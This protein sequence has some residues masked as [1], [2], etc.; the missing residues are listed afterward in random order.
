MVIT[1]DLKNYLTE[2]IE[3]TNAFI[4][5]VSFLEVDETAAEITYSKNPMDKA[6][7]L[8]AGAYNDYMIWKKG[9]VEKT[10]LPKKTKN[11]LK[12]YRQNNQ[13]VRIDSYVNGK[14]DVSYGVFIKG[15]H[16]YLIP[17]SVMTK[18]LYVATGT[19]VALKDK[20]EVM[21]SYYVTGNSIN[22]FDYRKIDE[23]TTA[24]TYISY[25]PAGKYPVL[26][27]FEGKI[28]AGENPKLEIYNYYNWMKKDR[29]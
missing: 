27:Y 21:E 10:T 7:C 4:K 18:R 26:E 12:Y 15:F 25:A 14:I 28:T 24:F 16:S 19:F 8:M 9:I 20:E 13:L 1:E 29:Q 11:Y 5:A 17:F 6:T 22:H 3:S 23:Y 2:L